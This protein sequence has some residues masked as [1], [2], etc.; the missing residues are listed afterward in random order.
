MTGG[1]SSRGFN[2]GG[3]CLWD[4][5]FYWGVGGCVKMEQ[6]PDMVLYTDSYSKI[7]EFQQQFESC[8]L[9]NEH[10]RTQGGCPGAPGAAPFRRP[11]HHGGPRAGGSC[12]AGLH[13]VDE[14][15]ASPQ[16]RNK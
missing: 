6:G 11:L 2:G 12:A 1:W 14:A 5:G 3:G 9:K 8:F 10:R 15:L 13:R 16:R 7:P 4:R